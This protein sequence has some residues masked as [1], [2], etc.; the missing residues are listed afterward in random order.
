MVDASF[1]AEKYIPIGTAPTKEV[2]ERIR[3]CK[4]WWN[5]IDRQVGD[6][7]ARVYIPD[8][9]IDEAFKVLAKKYYQESVYSSTIQLSG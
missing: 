1:I 2:K 3:E 8:V 4:R 7:R 9:C 6:E 5:E